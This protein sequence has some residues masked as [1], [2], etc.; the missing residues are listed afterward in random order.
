MTLMVKLGMHL[1]TVM[2]DLILPTGIRLDLKTVQT[3]RL[4]DADVA[5]VRSATDD[6]TYHLP[7]LKPALERARQIADALATAFPPH[8]REY[9]SRYY[10][11][12]YCDHYYQSCESVQTLA[13]ALGLYS[14]SSVTAAR[15]VYHTHA[16]FDEQHYGTIVQLDRYLADHPLHLSKD[17]Q[18]TLYIQW[19]ML[20]LHLVMPYIYP[21]SDEELAAWQCGGE[22]AL[23]EVYGL[24]SEH[25][26]IDARGIMLKEL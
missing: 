3:Y 15:G 8:L 13:D 24:S 7:A 26:D 17:E 2:S 22:R 18:E 19:I 25:I 5:S 16:D 4:N 20:G 14:A 6:F 12:G 9:A 10:Y 11:D 23:Q 21:L 1:V